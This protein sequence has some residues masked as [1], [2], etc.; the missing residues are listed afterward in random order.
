MKRAD[1]RDGK[2]LCDTGQESWRLNKDGSR[3]QTAPRAGQEVELIDLGEGREESWRD[4]VSVLGG[5]VGGGAGHKSSKGFE[6]GEVRE[7]MSLF[8][9]MCLI[10][11]AL[12]TAG[13]AGLEL[14]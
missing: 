5:W 6:W 1:W 10:G 14:R 4:P 13:G 2:A 3:K 12:Q 7:M 9:V 8:R 11:H